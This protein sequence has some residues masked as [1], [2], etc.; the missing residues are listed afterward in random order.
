MSHT[1]CTCPPA[2]APRSIHRLAARTD[3]SR[4]Q[5]LRSASRRWTGN[6][7]DFTGHCVGRGRSP[8]VLAPRAPGGSDDRQAAA[9]QLAAGL[10][11][12]VRV[13][14][15][16]GHAGDR[17]ALARGPR[18][19]VRGGHGGRS[20]DRPLSRRSSGRIGPIPGSD[21][22]RGCRTPQVRACVGLG[23]GGNREGT[24]SRRLALNSYRPRSQ[25]RIAV[26]WTPVF[27]RPK[28]RNPTEAFKSRAQDFPLRGRSGAG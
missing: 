4:I 15:P 2:T 22:L 25:Q 20:G 26:L 18:A 7:P 16:D 3:M 11:A 27:G 24:T 8:S 12:P 28:P 19:A 23:I 17:D 10:P 1:S 21:P 6:P 5:L 9:A 13:R 14:Q